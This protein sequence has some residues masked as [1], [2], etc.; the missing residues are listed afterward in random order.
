MPQLHFWQATLAETPHSALLRTFASRADLDSS[1][2]Q[3]TPLPPPA[4]PVAIQAWEW[5]E[6]R[7]LGLMTE[8]LLHEDDPDDQP[9]PTREGIVGCTVDGRHWV[10]AM[11]SAP[12]PMSSAVRAVVD[13]LNSAAESSE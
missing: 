11:C 7:N 2:F 9:C 6:A 12:E 10:V 5:R 8:E 4:G 3:I 13:Q 1:C